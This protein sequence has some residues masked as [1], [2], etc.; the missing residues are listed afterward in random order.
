MVDDAT[1]GILKVKEFLTFHREPKVGDK[2]RMEITSHDVIMPD[3]SRNVKATGVVFRDYLAVG[4]VEYEMLG[5]KKMLCLASLS[6]S[7][8]LTRSTKTSTAMKC[9]SKWTQ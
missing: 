4:G 5:I 8:L 3:Q 1:L 7:Q 6:V 2:L 9:S